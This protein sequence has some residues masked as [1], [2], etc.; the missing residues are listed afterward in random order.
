MKRCGLLVGDAYP[1][2][3]VKSDEHRHVIKGLV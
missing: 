2:R 3:Y 1:H